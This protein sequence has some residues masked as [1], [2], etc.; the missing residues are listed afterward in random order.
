MIIS[1]EDP[2]SIKQLIIS[3]V[4]AEIVSSLKEESEQY[5]MAVGEAV[6]DAL[7]GLTAVEI[8]GDFLSDF[9]DLLDGVRNVLGPILA[10]GGIWNKI[11]SLLLPFL[12]KVLNWLFGKS[13][14]EVLSEV[15]AKVISQCV[16]Q[17]RDAIQPTVLKI[18]ADNQKRIREKIQAELVS[19][20]EKVKEGLREKIADANKSKEEVAAEIAKLNEAIAQLDEVKNNL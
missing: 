19:K 15:K 11:I 13:D 17:V 3:T 20:M 14:E 1:R 12:P 8:D 7:R 9:Q 5:S 10:V 2:E 6:Q 16:T 4:R 18:T